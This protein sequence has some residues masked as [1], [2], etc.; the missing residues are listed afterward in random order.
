MT[1]IESQP[2]SRNKIAM[3]KESVVQRLP[4]HQ[5]KIVDKRWNKGSLSLGIVFL[6]QESTPVKRTQVGSC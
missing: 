4:Q 6:F 1:V 2:G 5:N 3:S